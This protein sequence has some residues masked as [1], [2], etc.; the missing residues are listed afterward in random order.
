MTMK[1]TGNGLNEGFGRLLGCDLE[2]LQAISIRQG[3]INFIEENSSWNLINKFINLRMSR[4]QE[5]SHFKGNM[6]VVTLD[7]IVLDV[8]FSLDIYLCKSG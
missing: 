8:E 3:I 6:S 2:S 7:E 1:E 5:D 4:F